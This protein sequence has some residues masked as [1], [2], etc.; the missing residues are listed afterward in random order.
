ML[1]YKLTDAN[2]QTRGKTQWGPGVTHAATGSP[3]QYLCSDGWIHAYEHPLLA[4]FLNPM[5]ARF[6]NPQLWEAEGEI[7]KREG[8]LKCGCR[9]LTTLKSISL[10]QVTTEQCV[11][12]AIAVVACVYKNTAWLSWAN[13]WIIVFMAPWQVE[14]L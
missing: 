13:E 11:R 8:Q 2:G 7:G 5:H 12:F 14:L 3:S 6:R 9:E 4:V 1:L 10:P